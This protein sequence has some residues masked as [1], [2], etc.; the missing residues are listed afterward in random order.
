MLRR[1]RR[2]LR[3]RAFEQKLSALPALLEG[4]RAAEAESEAEAALVIGEEVFGAEAA[5]LT[6]PLYVMAAARLSAGRTDDALAACTRAIRIAEALAGAPTEPRLPKLYELAA[7]IH[8]RAGTFDETI[9]LYRRL[10]A[11]YERMRTPDEAAIADV[12]GRLGL[13][14][15]K[16][17]QAAEAELLLGRALSI[18][19]RVHGARSRPS[20]EVLYNL[21]T[22]LAAAG[23][24]DDA[25]RSLRRAIGILGEHAP[26]PALLGAAQHN[27][28]TVLEA[29][30]RA[31]EA[32][33]MYR[34][35]LATYEAS[36]DHEHA[37]VRP[38]LV[39]LGHLL[40][41]KGRAGEARPFY[42]RA[43]ALAARDFGVDHSITAGI[44]AFLDAT[45]P[46]P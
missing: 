15:G 23:R 32:E 14:L 24:R 16:Q 39:R 4:E 36:T 25:A 17:K 34:E 8:E 12:A 26:R 42:E 37:D 40:V 19:E 5:E 38:T 1:L 43:Y 41:A 28:A 22:V 20:A 45:A 18:T 13:L 30:G 29:E 2:A 3:R 44:R 27:L 31:E 35:A 10:L 7:A 33:A 11:G 6:T 46:A 21:G 9:R